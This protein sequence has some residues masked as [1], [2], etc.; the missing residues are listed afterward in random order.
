MKILGDGEITKAFTVK[1]TKFSES[2]ATKIAAA[3]GK[4][5]VV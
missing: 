2:A 3:G 1:A 4:T 5:E